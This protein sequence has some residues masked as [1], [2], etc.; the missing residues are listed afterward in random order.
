MNNT[1]YIYFE[2]PNKNK[3]GL[4][5]VKNKFTEKMNLW[6]SSTTVQ[7]FNVFDSTIVL[8]CI[9]DLMAETQ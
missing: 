9:N 7:W 3:L 1:C 5:E 6:P 2:N 4:K 8:W